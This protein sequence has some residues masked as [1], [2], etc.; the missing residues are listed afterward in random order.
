MSKAQCPAC[1]SST[2]LFQTTPVF[3]SI[4]GWDRFIGERYSG[5]LVLIVMVSDVLDVF[6]DWVQVLHSLGIEKTDLGD[7]S[8][9]E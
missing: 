4:L 2:Y 9:Q 7:E 6:E 1:K 5:K 3:L 8:L